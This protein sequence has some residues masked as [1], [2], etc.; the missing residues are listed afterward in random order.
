MS[1]TARQFLTSVVSVRKRLI[2]TNACKRY[3]ND[4]A[5]TIMWAESLLQRCPSEATVRDFLRRHSG[6][7]RELIPAKSATDSRIITLQQLIA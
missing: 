5:V 7:V 1:T 6:R 3:S 4:M 2:R